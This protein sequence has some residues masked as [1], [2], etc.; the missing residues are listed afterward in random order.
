MN[1]RRIQNQ[2][3]AYLDN[4]LHPNERAKV[5]THLNTCDECVQMLADF[6]QNR[7]WIAALEHQAPP[8]ADL[9]MAKLPDRDSVRRRSLLDFVAIWHW[10][11]R[12]AT[13]GVFALATAC[14]VFALILFQPM[15]PTPEDPFAADPIELYLAV[16]NEQ[17]TYNPL[18]SNAT[19]N[20]Y[21]TN[22]QTSNTTTSDDTALLLEVYFGD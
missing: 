4:Q 7:Q 3:S 9:V 10:F 14:L 6:Q 1:H 15:S 12:P 5:E 18:K 17:L 21:D 20:S 19:L 16:H 22:H 13:G 2:L 8:I 11:C